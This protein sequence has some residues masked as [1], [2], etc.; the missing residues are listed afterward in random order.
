MHLQEGR[1]GTG[2]IQAFWD[3]E[4]SGI[5]VNGH[6]VDNYQGLDRTTNVSGF[7]APSKNDINLRIDTYNTNAEF[8]EGF[9]SST[10][11]DFKGS[12]NGTLNVIGPLNDVNLVGDI[13]ADVSMRLF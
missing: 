2:Y 1:L 11:R 13:S 3:K 6:I 10:F 8:L 7:I 5:R 12:T 9:L 4:I